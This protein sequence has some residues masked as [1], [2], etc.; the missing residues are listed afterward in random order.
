MILVTD[1]GQK[2]EKKLG[3]FADQRW[4]Q[5]SRSFHSNA[6]RAQEH[7][8]VSEN[9]GTPNHTKLDDFSIETHDF[10]DI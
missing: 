10:G 9:R 6:V 1:P 4:A 8:E 5:N 3:G 7:M 2:A